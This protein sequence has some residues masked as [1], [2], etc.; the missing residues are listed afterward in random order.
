MGTE[1]PPPSLS[2]EVLQLLSLFLEGGL[3]AP[4]SRLA[5]AP[6]DAVSCVLLRPGPGRSFPGL[7]YLCDFSQT[8]PEPS[9]TLSSGKQNERYNLVFEVVGHHLEPTLLVS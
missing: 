7:S 2:P 4:Q 8:L 9:S 3:H 5:V 1:S 6:E